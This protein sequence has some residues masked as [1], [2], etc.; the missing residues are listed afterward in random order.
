M[1][2][3]LGSM[4]RVIRILLGV[5][6]L[7]FGVAGGLESPWNYIADG[8]GVVL[9]LTSTIKFCPAYAIIGASTCQKD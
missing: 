7:A 6:A 3:N 1:K 9:L 2:A 4:D 5:G 8:V